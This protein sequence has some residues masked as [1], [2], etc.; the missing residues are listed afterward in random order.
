MQLCLS[1]AGDPYVFGSEA[2]EFVADFNAR[3]RQHPGVE[4]ID[5]ASLVAAF[6]THGVAGLA[7]NNGLTEDE[8]RRLFTTPHVMEMIYLILR[9]LKARAVHPAMPSA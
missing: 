5:Y 2:R 3:A 1:Q 4:P 6:R 7:T 8:N 9:G